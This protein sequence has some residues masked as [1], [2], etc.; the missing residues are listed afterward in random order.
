M[1]GP[2]LKTEELEGK[3]VAEIGSGTGRVVD[4]LLDAGSANVMAIEP[5]KG[6]YDVLVENTKARKERVT[7]IQ[8]PGD[9]IPKGANLDYVFSIGVIHH[10]P[11]PKPVISASRDALKAGGKLLIWIYG[12]EGNEMYLSIA[13]PLRKVTKLLPHSVLVALT[14]ILVL[15]LDVYIALCRFIP[16]PMHVYMRSVLANFKHSVRRMTIYDQLNPAYAKY[17]FQKDGEALLTEAGFIDVHSFHRHAY[18][19]SVIGTKK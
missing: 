8:K 15:F 6:A 10:I 18:S 7:Y 11:D 17:Y 2:L 13:L 14:W 5:A 4:M 19:W 9:E 16:L 3:R 12:H 1:F